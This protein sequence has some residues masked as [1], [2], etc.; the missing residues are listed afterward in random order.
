MYRNN[1]SHIIFEIR[2]IFFFR[3]KLICATKYMLFSGVTINLWS[4]GAALNFGRPSSILATPRNPSI[5]FC[6]IYVLSNAHWWVW[7]LI[8]I[9]FIH[10]FPNSMAL[11]SKRNLKFELMSVC[12]RLSKSH[13]SVI[14]PLNTVEYL[15]FF[16]PRREA[17]TLSWII[18]KSW[19]KTK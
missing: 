7:V 6:N 11:I 19:S 12:L 16:S 8:Y 3:R 4:S 15:D 18:S 1:R 13:Y 17:E 10:F 2:S 14:T 5:R 9:I